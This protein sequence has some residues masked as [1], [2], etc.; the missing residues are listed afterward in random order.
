MKIKFFIV[1]VLAIN[2]AWA[3]PPLEE[4]K[5]LFSTRC[6][7][8]HNVNKAL[9]GPAL[10]G[11]DERRSMEWIAN[12]I[13]SSQAM[14]KAG[15]KDAIAV[16]EQFNKIP[17][18]DHPDLSDDHIKSIVEFIKS[19]SSNT[20]EV[21]PFARPSK[22][23]PSYTPFALDDYEFFAAFTVA[24]VLLIVVLI[25]SVRIKEIQRNVSTD[26]TA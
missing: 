25:V 13:R 22:L 17:M 7:S 21:A 4:G 5:V 3:N 23:R 12:F 6:A 10:A 9:T 18:P 16:Y 14:V 8:C 24:V 19:E 15:D 1:A 11:L 20:A 26:E 2:I